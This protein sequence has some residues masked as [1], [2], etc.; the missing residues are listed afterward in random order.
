MKNLII[1]IFINVRNLVSSYA[2]IGFLNSATLFVNELKVAKENFK[3]EISSIETD[4]KF[5]N[6]KVKSFYQNY[7][8]MFKQKLILILQI[9]KDHIFYVNNIFNFP[10][11]IIKF[12]IYND[13]MNTKDI[14]EGNNKYFSKYKDNFITLQKNKINIIYINYNNIEQIHYYIGQKNNSENIEIIGK[15]INFLYLEKNK[16]YKLNFQN[17]TINRMIKLSRKS[18]NS[19]INIEGENTKLNSD[20]L[21]YQIKDGFEG[22]ITLEVTKNDAIVEF[23]FKFQDMEVIDF[24]SLKIKTS[25]KYILIKF[26]KKYSSKSISIE[27]KNKNNI[28]FNLFMGY[29]R[30]PY[31]YYYNTKENINLFGAQNNTFKFEIPIPSEDKIIENEYFCALIEN[32][33]EGDLEIKRIEQEH[34]KDKKKNGLEKWKLILISISSIIALLIIIVLF[35]YCCTKK[36]QLSNKQIEEKM[37]NLNEIKEM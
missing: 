30:P 29:S 32:M 20:N 17:N 33:V 21:Y 18:L 25:K 7:I 27:L 34:N 31:S 16:K 3:I 4:F 1:I 2:K 15:D 28:F 9:P 22:E 37:E 36:N 6:Y 12:A 13:E 23:L 26:S 8:R 24:E 5:S 11:N 35:I 10:Q 19:E 14:I